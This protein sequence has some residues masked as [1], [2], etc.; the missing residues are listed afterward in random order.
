MGK[1]PRTPPSMPETHTPSRCAQFVFN[2]NLLSATN[3]N[4]N[5]SHNN[6]QMNNDKT[7]CLL[8]A[9]FILLSKL[10]YVLFLIKVVS[11]LYMSRFHI[12]S[13]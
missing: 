9:T 6:K 10:F 2:D 8:S 3:N 7:L 12:G 13:V 5:A 4:G 1:S 11:K